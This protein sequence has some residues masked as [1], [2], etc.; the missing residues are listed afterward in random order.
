[1]K[2]LPSLLLATV[3]GFLESLPLLKDI[4]QAIPFDPAGQHTTPEE[5]KELYARM[6]KENRVLVIGN[7]NMNNIFTELKKTIVYHKYPSNILAKQS[8]METFG[9]KLNSVIFFRTIT[10]LKKCN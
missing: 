2:D 4:E 8:E 7:S 6:S 3:G 10:K 5:T 9:K 1:M